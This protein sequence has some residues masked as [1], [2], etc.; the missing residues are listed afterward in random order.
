LELLGL[1]RFE[2]K[3]VGYFGKVILVHIENVEST[4]AE[5]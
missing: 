1:V 5:K 4:G 3:G 2:G